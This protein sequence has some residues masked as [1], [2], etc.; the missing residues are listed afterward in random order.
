MSIRTLKPGDYISYHVGAAKDE[1]VY[2]KVYKIVSVTPYLK[3]D[4]GTLIPLDSETV[5]ITRV[6][7]QTFNNNEYNLKTFKVQEES[8]FCCIS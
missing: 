2:T 8:I 1:S 4:D 7:H 5:Y 3:L 6:N